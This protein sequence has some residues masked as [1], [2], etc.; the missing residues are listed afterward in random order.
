MTKFNHFQNLAARQNSMESLTRM[1][2]L[3]EQRLSKLACNLSR[4]NIRIAAKEAEIVACVKSIEEEKYGPTAWLTPMREGLLDT[5]KRT[6]D[7]MESNRSEQEQEKERIA[8]LLS[9]NK[10]LLATLQND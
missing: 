8:A 3:C 4:L 6:L 10:A 7:I 1:I 2:N 5:H 9:N